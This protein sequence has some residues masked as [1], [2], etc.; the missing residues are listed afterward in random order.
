LNSSK[1]AHSMDER[2]VLFC[3]AAGGGVF[4]AV[5][6][7]L[8]G[9]LAGLMARVHGRS[10]GGFLGWRVLRAVERV[11]QHDIAPVPAGAL[12]GAIDGAAF[13]GTVGVLL[14][15]VAGK[16]DWLPPPAFLAIFLSIGMIAALAAAI[17]S[18]AYLLARGGV[19]AAGP[20]CVGGVAGICIGMW[21][22]GAG[23]V[24][25]GAWLGLLLGFAAGWLGVGREPRTRKQRIHWEE[26]EP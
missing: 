14:G 19:R 13:L 24:M 17:G 3:W 26:H 18:T 9:G 7:A 6:G 22:A 10:P 16:T 15:L 23:G 4:L 2:F 1:K 11:L 12:V 25:V 20:V 8:F 21:S 5:V